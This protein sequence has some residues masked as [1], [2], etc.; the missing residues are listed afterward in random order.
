MDNNLYDNTYNPEP[1]NQPKERKGMAIASMIVGIVS[2]PLACCSYPGIIAGIVGLLLAI[3]SKNKGATR[4]GLSIAGIITSAIGIV[5]GTIIL[6]M[7][8]TMM[9]DSA[10]MEQY[11]ELMEF[12]NR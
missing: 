4:S 12:Y 3:F 9:A 1:D 6:I 5:L 11:N 10:F 7:T 8:L 2:I